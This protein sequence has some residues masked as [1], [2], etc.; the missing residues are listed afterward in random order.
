MELIA[1]KNNLRTIAKI[2]DISTN[3]KRGINN[4]FIV[5]GKYL[6][7]TNYKDFAD[8]KTGRIYTLTLN[9]KVIKHQASA[10]YEP[11]AKFTGRLKSSIK[12]KTS[13]SYQLRYTAGNN[14]AHY[15]KYLETGTTKMRPRPYMS[16]SVKDNKGKIIAAFISNL[17]K[18][19]K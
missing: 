10:P 12:A 3:F 15:A 5:S 13:G 8:K 18:K 7:D 16:K 9:G 1:S 2:K 19:L 14:R 6:K 4:G 17:S 11:P